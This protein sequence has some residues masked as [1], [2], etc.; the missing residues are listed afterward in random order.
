MLNCHKFDSPLGKPKLSSESN[1]GSLY[2]RE[3]YCSN[4]VTLFK[5]IFQARLFKSVFMDL[6]NFIHSVQLLLN[7]TVFII[8]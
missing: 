1:G 5:L 4:S 8:I 2:L 3:G 6:N 7:L